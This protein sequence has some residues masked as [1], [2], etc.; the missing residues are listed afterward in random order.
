MG[1]GLSNN[2]YAAGKGSTN[3]NNTIGGKK[4]I[5]D[6]TKKRNLFSTTYGQFGTNPE[7]DYDAGNTVMDRYNKL[8]NI[9]PSQ[10]SFD[11]DTSF[12]D[13]NSFSNNIKE[14]DLPGLG[15]N[16]VGQAGQNASFALGDLDGTGPT[17][18]ETDWL[19]W[20]GI[21]TGLLEGAG[22]LAQGYAAIKNLGIANKGLDFK[23]DVYNTN[24]AAQKTAFNNPVRARQ[25]ILKSDFYNDPNRAKSLKL[26]A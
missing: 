8:R 21:G 9:Q 17:A 1:H 3:P 7:L 10:L 14:L 5:D 12:V 20:A 23:R 6:N 13:N 19:G 26:I 4:F 25:D 22:G 16:P 15:Y 18:Q 11:G 24:L 2:S